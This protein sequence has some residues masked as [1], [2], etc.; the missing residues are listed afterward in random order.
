MSKIAVLRVHASYSRTGVAETD[1]SR[2]KYS[3]A[4]QSNK[5][6]FV[7]SRTSKCSVPLPPN[8]VEGDRPR[9]PTEQ[10]SSWNEDSSGIGDW[11]TIF[12]WLGIP[13]SF[14][15]LHFVLGGDIPLPT[16]TYLLYLFIYLF[17]QFTFLSLPPFVPT[18]TVPL[19]NLP[20]LLLWKGGAHLP[21]LWYLKSLQH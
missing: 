20:P 16:I 11:W 14:Q 9:H 13:F 6:E 4:D 21:W 2:C 3:L 19:P 5:N 1:I 8:K 18:H 15:R 7:T 10:D 12:E 17:I